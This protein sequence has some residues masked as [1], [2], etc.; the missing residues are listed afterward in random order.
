LTGK[1]YKFFFSHYLI[2]EKV[3]ILGQKYLCGHIAS[4][5]KTACLYIG[6]STVVSE[7]MA[8]FQLFGCTRGVA[9][10]GLLLFL[11]SAIRL[12]SLPMVRYLSIII[13]LSCLRFREK[14]G[15]NLL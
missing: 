12:E 7:P 1:R 15:S 9:V 5:K 3:L 6:Y 4:H 10:L 8:M 13:S 11:I 2:R 14:N